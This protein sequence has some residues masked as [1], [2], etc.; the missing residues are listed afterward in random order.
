[1]LTFENLRQSHMVPWSFFP[2]AHDSGRHSSIAIFVS[3]PYVPWHILRCQFQGLMKSTSAPHFMFHRGKIVSCRIIGKFQWFHPMK[4]PMYKGKKA[5]QFLTNIATRGIPQFE[6]THVSRRWS[7]GC[8]RI[9]L[10]D[11]WWSCECALEQ[12]SWGNGSIHVNPH[13]VYPSDQTWLAGKS[14][15]SL[16]IEMWPWSN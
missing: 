5:H 14:R 12:F 13:L 15:I 6:T 1:M 4:H 7:F 3:D 8:P 9:R 10:P 16:G 2:T 11:A